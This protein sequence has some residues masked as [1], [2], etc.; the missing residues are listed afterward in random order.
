[1]TIQQLKYVVT[2]SDCGSI[3][4]A[5]KQLFLSQPSLSAAIK[6]LEQEIKIQIF[7]RNNRGVLTTPEGSEFLG[8]ARQIIQQTELIETKYIN[9][10]CV[11][12]RFAVSTQHYAFTASAFVDLIKEFGG[13]EYEFTLRETTTFMIIEDVKSFRSEMGVLY[14]SRFNKQV[15]T[16]LL[17][18]ND[19]E[20]H[21]LFC[22]QPHVFIGRHSPLAKRPSLTLD[23]LEDLPYLLFDQGEQNSFYFAE[24]VLST[25]TPKKTIRVT[26]R[27]AVIN[28]I[29]GVGAYTISTGV[30]PY[31]LNGADIVAVP[32]A[33][34]ETMQVG[35]VYRT[36]YH[37]TPLGGI[38][39]QALQ[40]IAQQVE[41]EGPMFQPRF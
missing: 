11:K 6:E 23:D 38:Y 14:L 2:V 12:Q 15:I 18:E 5:A 22:V 1:M 28:L 37:P 41:A 24:E 31:Y 19:L 36:N 27:A 16:K 35:T 39:L 10:A 25:R 8:Y 13:D 32:L 40:R 9:G 3:S 21:P 26:D 20:F 29:V 34:N 7:F 4:E 17:K 30:F 33:V